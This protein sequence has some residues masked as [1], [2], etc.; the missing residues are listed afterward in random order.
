MQDDAL[1]CVS[2]EMGRRKLPSIPT[3]RTEKASSEQPAPVYLTSSNISLPSSPSERQYFLQDTNR[4]RPASRA[5]SLS[6]L[7]RS[8][9]T[10][11][12]TYRGV[13]PAIIP[14][15]VI[16]NVR[17]KTIRQTTSTATGGRSNTLGQSSS[18]M[19]STLAR[20]LLKKELKEVLERRREAL[21]ACEIEA[22]QREFVVHRMLITGLLPEH[23]SADID[24]IPNVI[25]CLLPVELVNGAKIVPSG[26]RSTNTS[27][28]SLSM[29]TDETSRATQGND[30]V[31]K[32]ENAVCSDDL[33]K[34]KVKSIA[35]QVEYKPHKTK[36]F[37]SFYRPSQLCSSLSAPKTPQE[38]F[39]TTK[40]K[41]QS[42]G[43]QTNGITSNHYESSH[44]S[45]V[46][47]RSHEATNSGDTYVSSSEP[48]LLESTA[49]YFAEYDRQLREHGRRL[50]NRF[51][52]SDDDPISRES[53]KQRLISE[54]AQRKEKISSMADL[55]NSLNHS[56]YS[57]TV[58][59]YGSL[60]IID[61][62]ASSTTHSLKIPRD[63]KKHGKI[64]YGS[65]P[66]NY[67]RHMDNCAYEPSCNSIQPFGIRQ[68][69]VLSRSLHDL[70]RSYDD[71]SDPRIRIRNTSSFN[72]LPQNDAYDVC[73]GIRS[74]FINDSCGRHA[75]PEYLSLEDAQNPMEADMISQYAN[76]LS[77]EFMNNQRKLLAEYG[78]DIPSA[79]QRDTVRTEP[80]PNFVNVYG[81][82]PSNLCPDRAIYIKR[83]LN[84]YEKR[85]FI[86]NHSASPILRSNFHP[87]HSIQQSS[88]QPVAASSQMQYPFMPSVN[89]VPP[90]G[91]NTTKFPPYFNE[92]YSRNEV[93][94]GSRPLYSLP[95]YGN[96]HRN[97]FL[98]ES[99][100]CFNGNFGPLLEIY[101]NSPENHGALRD[102]Q[103]RPYFAQNAQNLQYSYKPITNYPFPLDQQI[104]QY[105]MG[106]NRR[107]GNLSCNYGRAWLSNG[108]LP[109]ST[110]YD[111]IYPKENAKGNFATTSRL[112]PFRSYQ[113]GNPSVLT[114]QM[115]SL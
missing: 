58:P 91:S 24:D 34:P 49:K 55:S 7:S 79:F 54:L 59:H 52:F 83:P 65:L 46:T 36:Q 87:I 19:P 14:G 13:D 62:P 86:S 66:R 95:E 77:N 33:E 67:E 113:T 75:Y 82:A 89:Y 45:P 42:T 20:V 85:T 105:S 15:A 98:K 43:T 22:N 78:T 12:S 99:D 40:S 1:S 60:P 39:I 74:Q 96:F 97:R 29:Q 94:Y 4:S 50:K 93:N 30:F 32:I 61:F 76:Y 108:N 70:S 17:Q 11:A 28:L 63:F 44:K 80:Y 41:F 71:I 107:F 8:S 38:A 109:M 51:A 16:P 104:E 64:R 53:K 25:H 100:A 35:I 90:T 92:V 73:H 21:E 5:S 56:D 68:Y 10:T 72:H 37:A 48:N 69:D 57:S 84:E 114:A 102:Q 47:G 106:N 3:Q 2:S 18:R 88:Y 112:R 111:A 81:T 9:I 26:E 115:I 103:Y 6:D 23:R 27:P 101:G 110:Y 31:S